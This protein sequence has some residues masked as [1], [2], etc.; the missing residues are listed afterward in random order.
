MGGRIVNDDPERI[1]KEGVMAKFEALP[2][3][4]LTGADITTREFSS[5][6]NIAKQP[7]GT[8]HQ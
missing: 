6:S 2:R 5:R 3:H 7:E 8:V 1:W 4:F